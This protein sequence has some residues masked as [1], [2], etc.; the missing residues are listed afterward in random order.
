M[1]Q[2]IDTW[3]LEQNA[4]QLTLLLPGC[5]PNAIIIL[6][7]TLEA[8]HASPADK[9]ER[10]CAC[11]QTPQTLGNFVA[12]LTTPVSVEFVSLTSPECH[13]CEIFCLFCR[14]PFRILSV[15]KLKKMHL[16]LITSV[17]CRTKE[18]HWPLWAKHT[19]HPLLSSL[20][21]EIFPLQ[22]HHR[23][24]MELKMYNFICR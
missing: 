9:Q 3:E 17:D 10:I 23:Q 13:L 24:Q 1:L 15:R 11:A 8:V 2:V 5:L 4:D 14:R 12:F 21:S 20:W 19:R 22:K 6:E 18:F 16:K 7:T